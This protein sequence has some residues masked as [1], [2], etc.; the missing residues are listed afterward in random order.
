[1]INRRRRLHI[2][3]PYGKSEAYRAI[4]RVEAILRHKKIGQ[5]SKSDYIKYRKYMKR[6]AISRSYLMKLID[7][8]DHITEDLAVGELEQFDH[9]IQLTQNEEL[10]NIIGLEF[11]PSPLL[12]IDYPA[13]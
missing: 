13:F 1:M 10:V 12:T 9:M 2:L 6:I 4:R 5:L 3:F 8:G 11:D 7:S